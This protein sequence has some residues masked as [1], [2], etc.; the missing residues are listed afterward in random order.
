LF[1]L[2]FSGCH[3][4]NKDKHTLKRL[5]QKEEL[6]IDLQKSSLTHKNRSVLVDS[7]F[8]DFSL[9]IIPTGKFSFSVAKGFEG[10]AEK[11]LFKGKQA[12]LHKW[13]SDLEIKQNNSSTKVSH[14]KQKQREVS[15]QKHK[16]SMGTNL[17]W[18]FLIFP[19]CY[20]LWR[21]KKRFW[22]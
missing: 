5:N 16:F 21:I 19:I 20:C 4:L 22:F 18:L 8:G 1:G 7:S 9:T 14:S 6:H 13:M 2:V 12:N 10:K 17:I 15:V 3:I 11:L